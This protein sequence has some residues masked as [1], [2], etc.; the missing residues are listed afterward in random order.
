MLALLPLLAGASAQTAAPTLYVRL[1]DP[2]STAKAKP[3]D[4]VG[5]VTIT[6]LTVAGRTVATPGCAMPGMVKESL[7][8]KAVNESETIALTFPK[9]VDRNQTA[10]AITATIIEVDNGRETVDKEGRIRGV[11]PVEK[12]PESA[13]DALK[14]AAN[15]TQ[16]MRA[17]V[18]RMIGKVPPQID[19][20]AGT[21][22]IVRID[23]LPKAAS[24]SCG[25]VVPALAETEELA[26]I[27]NAQPLRS[28]TREGDKASD[29]TNLVFIGTREQ[30][31]GAFAEAGWL[32]AEALS[33]TSSA[34]TF[35]ATVAGEGYKEAPV[36]AQFID[37]KPPDLV[38][39][40]Q[41]NTFAKRH[42]L[43]IWLR[44]QTIN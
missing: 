11:A 12:K 38:F 2:V 21:E 8:P 13:S 29:V 39:Q 23:N 22:L 31:S 14:V 44:S 7:R 28:M 33:A 17:L 25:P 36:S 6:R 15:G 5:A 20:K 16:I 37:G 41:L 32:T 18:S 10:H 43:R 40:K 26:R 9:L 27:V 4:P 34:K 30:I 1:L 24:V 42:H 3:G 35:L 19:Y